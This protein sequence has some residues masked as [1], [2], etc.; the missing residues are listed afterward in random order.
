MI[1]DKDVKELKERT[2]GAYSYDSYKNWE[3]VC[4]WL[5][6]T[7][8]CMDDAEVILL[9]KWTRWAGDG[10]NN[11][12]GHCTSMDLKNF[13]DDMTEMYFNDLGIGRSFEVYKKYKESRK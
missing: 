2:E 5:L 6:R 12:Y 8:I 10:S 7:G 13:M 4:R 3:A 11:K 1:T 9:S